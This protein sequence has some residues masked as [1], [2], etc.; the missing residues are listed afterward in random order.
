MYCDFLRLFID[1]Y[2][3]WGHMNHLNLFWGEHIITLIVSEAHA[4][5]DLG[6]HDHRDLGGMITLI[7][8]GMITLIFF[9]GGGLQDHLNIFFGRG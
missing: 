7:W 3:L 4:H 5:L 2:G 6:G 9:L 1:V 8:G